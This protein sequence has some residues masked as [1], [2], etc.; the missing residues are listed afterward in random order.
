MNL[1]DERSLVGIRFRSWSVELPFH[2]NSASRA[3]EERRKD[4]MT[5]FRLAILAFAVMLGGS[6][7]LADDLS[8]GGNYVSVIVD[9][10][11]VG[12]TNVGG[13]P[14]TISYLNSIQLAWVYCVGFFT[15]VNVP[16]DYPT[17]VVTNNGVVNGALVNN[18]G[19]IAWLLDNLAPGAIGNVTAE[20]A[21]QAAIWSVEYNGQGINSAVNVLTGDSGQSYY[22]QYQSDLT[23][24]GSNTAA[25]NTI[26]WFT[27][28]NGSGG[29]YQGLAG[30]LPGKGLVPAI[31]EPSSI[32]LL[33]TGLLFSARLMT[34]KK[35]DVGR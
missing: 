17:T 4:L 11:N 20:Q 13:G 12:Q 35:F 22:S 32:L 8:L 19:E 16:A 33:G 21:L 10:S 29:P 1:M 34:R 2:D 25:L 3:S 15:E 6:A 7:A 27:P 31:P 30:P 23:A 24:L 9:E 18:A 26:D 28:A 5:R 14:I